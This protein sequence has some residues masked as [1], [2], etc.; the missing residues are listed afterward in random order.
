VVPF[1]SFLDIIERLKVHPK[2]GAGI[3]K[4]PDLYCSLGRDV[5]FASDDLPKARL[6]EPCFFGEPVRRYSHR[7]KKLFLKHFAGMNVLQMFHSFHY[8][9][10]VIVG[11]LDVMGASVSPLKA[12]APL[13][14]DT[15]TPLSF[16]VAFQALKSVIG[17]NVQCFQCSG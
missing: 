7:P 17:R 11:Y 4:A 8:L 3:Q 5:S 16:S 9:R 1:L 14:I 13:L 2:R 10:S 12:N 15:N 6:G